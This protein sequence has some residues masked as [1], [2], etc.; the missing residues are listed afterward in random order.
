[1]YVHTLIISLGTQG[2]SLPEN[3]GSLISW[4]NKGQSQNH[5]GIYWKVLIQM[6][7]IVYSGGFSAFLSLHNCS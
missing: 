3:T 6:T 5:V 4:E 1:M 7:T 2:Q